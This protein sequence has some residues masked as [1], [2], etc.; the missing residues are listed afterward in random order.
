MLLSV[1]NKPSWL[2][3]DF[4]FHLHQVSLEGLLVWLDENGATDTVPMYGFDLPASMDPFPTH[5]LVYDTALA[6]MNLDKYTA[7]ACDST[8][9]CWKLR[10]GNDSSW[11]S[12][13]PIL[14]G[15]STGSGGGCHLDFGEEIMLLGSGKWA[16]WRGLIKTRREPGECFAAKRILG[17]F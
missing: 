1:F 7:M 3:Y 13:A 12:V 9:A 14:Y 2:Y 16:S 6:V 11:V 4:F 5:P 15:Q 8:K 10:P 17:K